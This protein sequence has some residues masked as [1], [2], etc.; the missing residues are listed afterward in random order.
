MP[1]PYDAPEMIRSCFL[2]LGALLLGCSSDSFTAANGDASA[3]EG[4]LDAGREGSTCPGLSC[5]GVCTDPSTDNANCGKCGNVCPAFATCTNG[6]CICDKGKRCG[7]KCVQLNNDPDNCGQ[8]GNKCGADAGGVGSFDCIG[9]NCIPGCGGGQTSCSGTCYDLKITDE[10]CGTCDNDC[11]KTGQSC[12]EG[13]CTTLLTDSKNCG[14]CGN[15]CAMGSCS[16]GKCCNV[17]PVGMCPHDLCAVGPALK[18]G[19]DPNSCVTTICTSDPFCCSTNWDNVCVG[20]V[21]S[22]CTGLTC[23]CK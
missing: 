20:E 5:S 6:A 8:C 18:N 1:S 19:C 15:A 13:A 16:S 12:C 4:G 21:A 7:N 14:T 10:H 3:N 22:K 23:T 9:G 2:L 11:T 17:P